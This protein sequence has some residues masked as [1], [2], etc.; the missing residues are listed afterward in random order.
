[1]KHAKKIVSLLLA[2]VMVFAMTTTVFA[3]G[4]TGSITI[5]DNT[6][7]SVAGKT[8]NAYQILNVASYTDDTVVYTVPA[9][10]KQFYMNRYGLTGNE[11]DFD[12]Q[13]VNNIAD[14]DDLFDFAADALAAAKAASITP[15]TATA[16]EG[17]ESVTIRNLP[18]GYYVV[19]DVGAATPISALILDTTNPDVDIEIKADKPSVEKKIDG[20]KDTDESTRGDVDNNNAAVGDTV[21][22]KVTSKVP[23][24]TGYTKYYFVLNDKLSSGLTFNNDVAITLG[25]KKLVK[26]IDYTVTTG[27]DADGNT[28]IEIVFKNFIQYKDQVGAA[29]T[30]TYSAVLNENAV[31]GVEGNPNEVTLTYSNNPNVKD[32]GT[33]DNPDK[34]TP[35]S[36]TGE[37][38]K[39]ETRTYVT[40]IE[41]IKVDQDGKRLAGAEFQITG[42]KLNKVLVSKEVFTESADGEYWKLKDGTYTTTA[43]VEADDETDTTEYYDDINTKYTKEVVD[44][45]VTVSESVTATGTVDENGVLTFKGLAAGT[46]TITEIKAPAGYNLLKD[47]ITVTIGWTAPGEG[48]TDCTWTYGGTDTEGEIGTNHVTVTNQAGV[49]LPSTG[50]MGTTLFYIIGGILVIGAAVLLITKKRMNAKE[51]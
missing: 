36:P 44:E 43:P 29:I 41:I 19:E 10:L 27:T 38:P 7:V 12:A 24:M 40:G 11:G 13:V 37:T 51:S 21:P 22:Y 31:I 30:V 46:Y 4:E 17:A 33:P 26:D 14:E 34:P 28:T 1:M 8:F 47:P 48:A 25:D 9:E 5:N 45:V 20:V 32:E 23:D 49:E 42:T 15:G 18:L 6:N 35:I 2:L 3:A 39:D 16:G 50:G